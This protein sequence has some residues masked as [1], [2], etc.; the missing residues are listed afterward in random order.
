MCVLV[1]FIVTMCLSRAISS[2]LPLLA[3]TW[4]PVGRLTLK[5]LMTSRTARLPVLARWGSRWTGAGSFWTPRP[6]SSRSSSAHPPRC[7]C[8]AAAGGGARVITCSHDRPLPA[9]QQSTHLRTPVQQYSTW[10]GRWT[11]GSTGGLPRHLVLAP[12]R[13]L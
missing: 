5:S 9:N 6:A 8:A 13:P 10:P 12:L 1:V 4:L 2:I 7:C 3:C 11:R